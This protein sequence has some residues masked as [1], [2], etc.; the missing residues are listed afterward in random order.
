MLITSSENV[1]WLLNIR[2]HDSNFSPIPNSYLIIDKKIGIFLFC[3]M[4]KINSKLRKK[5]SFIKVFEFEILEKILKKI[6]NKNFSIDNSTCSI[7]YKDII[8]KK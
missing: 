6:K 7:F 4:K 2:G 1:A 5:L 3:N 8:K